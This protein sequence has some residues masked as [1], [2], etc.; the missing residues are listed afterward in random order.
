M[1]FTEFHL[2]PVHSVCGTGWEAQDGE[3]I[4]LQILDKQH[5]ADVLGVFQV[6]EAGEDVTKCSDFQLHCSSHT[7]SFISLL[8]YHDCPQLTLSM[9]EC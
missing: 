8:I 1:I 9:S 3:H 7:Y 2:L 5:E 4:G 6:P